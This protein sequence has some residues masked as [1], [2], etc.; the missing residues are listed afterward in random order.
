LQV[1][2]AL[3]ELYIEEEDYESLRQ[4]IDSY[5]NF[6]SIALARKLENNE[7]QLLEFR[8]ISARLYRQNKRWKKSIDISKTDK[9]YKDAME[10]AMQSCDVEIAHDL[11]EYFVQNDNKHCFAACLYTCY[12]LIRPDFALELAWRNQIIDF[13]FPFLIQIL[14]EYT[15][16][17]DS[18][19]EASKKRAEKPESQ[20]TSPATSVP[21]SGVP[22]GFPAIP[23]NVP[24]ANV[25]MGPVPPGMM[26]S[27]QG[28]TPGPGGALIPSNTPVTSVPPGLAPPSGATYPQESF[29]YFG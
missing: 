15:S 24:M 1:N 4:S 2:E 10:T 9:M 28:Y 5:D 17:V 14:R 23:G 27:I 8:R 11:L 22:Y 7:E 21:T 26:V 25:P 20:P 12:D 3:N 19:E 13:A 16:R 18:L 6:D 29:N